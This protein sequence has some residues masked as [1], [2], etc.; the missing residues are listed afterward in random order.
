MQI[1]IKVKLFKLYPVCGCSLSKHMLRD[2]WVSELSNIYLTRPTII[3]LI[4]PIEVFVVDVLYL[5]DIGI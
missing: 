1:A 5:I 3:Q 2:C 4:I